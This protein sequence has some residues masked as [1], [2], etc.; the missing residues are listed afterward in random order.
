MESFVKQYVDAHRKWKKRYSLFR[1]IP[2]QV[3]VA[4]TFCDL[5]MASWNPGLN[6]YTGTDLVA[7]TMNWKK[8]LW[9]WDNVSSSYKKYLKEINI[10]A[11]SATWLPCT[12]IVWSVMGFYPYIDCDS[13]DIQTM[14]N[15]EPVQSS[16]D[17][18]GVL[19]YL[20]AQTPVGISWSSQFK[21]T[22]R[23]QDWVSWK[24]SIAVQTATSPTNIAS[25]IHWQAWSWIN[26]YWFIPLA[27]WDTGIQVV[28]SIQFVW[29]IWWLAAL[30][31][32]KPLAE[33]K[34]LEVAA[35]HEK[36]ILL[37]DGDLP[38]IPNDTY[39]SMI[40]APNGSVSGLAFTGSIKTIIL[41]S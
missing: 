11:S 17:W 6:F 1:K 10:K 16:N 2:S 24:E 37:S 19:A 12:F 18:D 34:L 13:V 8:W 31:L 7:S 32:F 27:H 25:F 40:C 15:T 9:H 5:T 41:N 35:W 36:N 28:E 39:L 30:V 23:N 20:V 33:T 38:E 22:Y 4:G 14:D 29:P 3:S 26:N 21:I